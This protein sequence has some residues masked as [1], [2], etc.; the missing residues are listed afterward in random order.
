MALRIR[1]SEV[2]V[3][4]I[5][6]QGPGGQHVNKVSTAIALRFDVA[7]STLPEDVKA[8]WL[9]SPQ[10]QVGADGVLTLKAQRFR[11]Q[12]ANR[13]DAWH[14]LHAL[15]ARFEHPPKARK[16]TRPPRASVQ[17]RRDNKAHRSQLKAMRRQS[18]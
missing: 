13:Q 16:P 15:L 14:R 7:A 4:A 3:T 2:V 9:Q 11:S 10:G 18:D 5:R 6:A 8:R 1:D 12:I 17:K